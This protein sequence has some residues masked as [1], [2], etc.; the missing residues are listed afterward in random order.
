MSVM[1]LVYEDLPEVVEMPKELQHHAVQII[2]SPLTDDVSSHKSGKSDNAGFISSFAGKW[3]G[4]P[5]VREEQGEYEDRER[6]E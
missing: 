5:L 2:I 6:L 4:V 3:K 1:K